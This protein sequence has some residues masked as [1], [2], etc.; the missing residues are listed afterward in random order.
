M[1][2]VMTAAD[3]IK[4]S[5]TFG[6]SLRVV[7]D[8]LEVTGKPTVNAKEFVKLLSMRKAEVIDELTPGKYDDLVLQDGPFVDDICSKELPPL[9]PEYW[10]IGTPDFA[11]AWAIREESKTRFKCALGCDRTGSMFGEPGYYVVAPVEFPGEKV[12]NDD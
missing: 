3:L 6:L 8:K 2:T 7:D 12:Q 1:D 5:E 11:T 4:Q 10:M 9:P